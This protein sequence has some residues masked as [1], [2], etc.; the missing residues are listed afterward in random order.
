MFEGALTLEDYWVRR[1][2]RAWF[3]HDAGLAAMEAAAPV[4]GELL[5]WSD[6]ER[7]RQIAAC[8][9]IHDTSMSFQS[10]R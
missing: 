4:M 2:A 6:E 9:A 1:S 8:R 5:G 7:A 10:A 3:D